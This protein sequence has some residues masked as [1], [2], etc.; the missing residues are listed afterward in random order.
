MYL[1]IIT[2]DVTMDT[3][4]QSL[5]PIIKLTSPVIK[6]R[7]SCGISPS[8]KN[9]LRLSRVHSLSL[10]VNSYYI[11]VRKQCMYTCTL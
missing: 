9:I 11:P 2:Y 1:H 5:L 4:N 7:A 10:S 8:S 6:M 3:I